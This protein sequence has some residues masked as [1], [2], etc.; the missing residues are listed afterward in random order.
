MK[1]WIVIDEAQN[2]TPKQVK[3]IVTR[4]GEGSKIILIGD[5]EQ[6]DQAFLDLRSN[7]LCYASEKMKGS[8]LCYQVSLLYDECERSK[9]AFEGAKRL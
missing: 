4:A 9:L 8:P 6:I 3:A 7:G 1:N 5:P 2:L